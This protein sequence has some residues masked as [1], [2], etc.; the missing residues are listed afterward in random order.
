[1]KPPSL[2]KMTPMASL[3]SLRAGE[4]PPRRQRR[5]ARQE[6]Q[7]KV[8]SRKKVRKRGG[9]AQAQISQARLRQM[10]LEHASLRG[11]FFMLAT[12]AYLNGDGQAAKQLSQ[13]GRKHEELMKRYY[14]QAT[15]QIFASTASAEDSRAPPHRVDLHQLTVPVALDVL[16]RLLQLQKDRRR[17]RGDAESWVSV[18]TGVG[19]HSQ[20]GR[21]QIRPAVVRHLKDNGYHYHEVDGEVL[22]RVT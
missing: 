22:V 2:A 11:K 9:N 8:V 18:I 14:L 21:A 16:N 6:G 3:P 12:R 19:K 5:R 10:A 1:M 15:E 7:F 13:E 20:G 17:R 4:A